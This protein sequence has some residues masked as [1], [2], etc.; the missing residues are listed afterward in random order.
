MRFEALRRFPSQ[1]SEVNCGALG[2]DAARGHSARL[3]SRILR[4]NERK[5][6]ATRL[7]LE[8]DQSSSTLF[9]CAR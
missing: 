1:T 4:Q 8:L 6:H 2:S 9:T 5:K 3:I 7:R